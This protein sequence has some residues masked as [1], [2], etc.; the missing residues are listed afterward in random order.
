M[1]NLNC[2]GLRS[3]NEPDPYIG[4]LIGC[5][6]TLMEKLINFFIFYIFLIKKNKLRRESSIRL[7]CW[8]HVIEAF[9]HFRE[10]SLVASHHSV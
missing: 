8:F 2:F 1:L 3:C 10:K 9:F 6:L 7:A 5:V 4:G